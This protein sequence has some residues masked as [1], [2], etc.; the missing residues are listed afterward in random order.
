M[1]ELL[2]VS[3]IPFA[4]IGAVLGI[5]WYGIKFGFIVTFMLVDGIFSRAYVRAKRDTKDGNESK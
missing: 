2:L 5:I 3:L 4:V 1:K